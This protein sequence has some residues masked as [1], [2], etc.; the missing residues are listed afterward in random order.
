MINAVPEDL[1]PS[2]FTQSREEFLEQ[3]YGPINRML[4]VILDKFVS[5]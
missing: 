1:S 2:E 3:D 4:V 5:L